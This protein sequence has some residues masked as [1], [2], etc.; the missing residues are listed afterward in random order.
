LSNSDA[1]ITRTELIKRAFRRIGIWTPSTNDL[2]NAVGLL[3][4][5]VKMIDVHGKWLWAID[6]TPTALTISSGTQSYSVGTAPTGIASYILE[7]IRMELVIG[8]A[9]FPLRII[10][11]DESVKSWERESSANGQPYLCYLEKR[12]PMSAQKIWVYPS[13]NANYSAQYTYR[14]RLYD[15][16]NASDNPDFPQ[17]WNQRLAVILAFH[18]APEYGYPEEKLGTLKTLADEALKGGIAANTEERDSVSVPVEY[19]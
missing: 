8:T 19:F 18:L 7:L 1:T 5:V 4:D 16:D 15:F 2:S 17:D 14:R 11:K 13:P 6:N 10:D 9:L 3:N 12:A